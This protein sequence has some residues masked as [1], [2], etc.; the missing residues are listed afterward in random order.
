MEG[1]PLGPLSHYIAIPLVVTCLHFNLQ[2]PCTL[3]TVSFL[4]C[5]CFV[6]C[7]SRKSG[8]ITSCEGTSLNSELARTRDCQDIW[9]IR[10]VHSWTCR[11]HTQSSSLEGPS[12]G[13]SPH[14]ITRFIQI[15]THLHVFRLGLPWNSYYSWISL[16]DGWLC[17]KF[18]CELS[19]PS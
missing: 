7:C 16:F 6:L 11:Q 9:E 15:Q 1:S 17:L 19:I 13:K 5:S 2:A 8:K 10:T 18:F 12:N 14:P 3:P 4:F